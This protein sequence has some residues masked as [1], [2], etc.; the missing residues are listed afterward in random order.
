M[1]AINTNN[2]LLMDGSPWDSSTNRVE[3][4][5]VNLEEN[6]GKKLTLINRP[7]SKT[8]WGN[9]RETKMLDLKQ[10][11]HSYTLQGY[12]MGSPQISSVGSTADKINL[13][14]GSLVHSGGVKNMTWIDDGG[15]VMWETVNFKKA[16]ARKTSKE[17]QVYWCQLNLIEGENR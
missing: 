14:L 9:D 6:W 16:M 3:L 8:N 4:H 1:G 12:I 5:S 13:M 2:V 15:T 11:D 10:I 17:E 7:R